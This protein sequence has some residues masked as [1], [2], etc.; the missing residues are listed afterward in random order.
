M[1]DLAVSGDNKECVTAKSSCPGSV[2]KRAKWVFTKCAVSVS[3]EDKVALPIWPLPTGAF[4]EAEEV[5]SLCFG[6]TV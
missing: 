4:G 6:G 3:G 1:Q 2:G 5:K